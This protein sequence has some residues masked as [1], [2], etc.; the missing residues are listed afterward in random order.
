MRKNDLINQ[1]RIK[2]RSTVEKQA[3]FTVGKKGGGNH[4]RSPGINAG[5]REGFNDLENKGCWVKLYEKKDYEGDSLL[6]GRPL[7]FAPAV[8]GPSVQLGKQGSEH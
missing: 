8:T 2:N 1:G 4:Y 6:T 3:I 7:E 5:S